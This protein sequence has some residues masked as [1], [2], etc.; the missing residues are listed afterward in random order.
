[1][2]GSDFD[3]ISRRLGNAGSRRK[4]LATL[5]TALGLLGLHDGSVFVLARRHK[6]KKKK[7]RG[8]TT[9]PPPTS[10]ITCPTGYSACG[11]Q[12]FD[13]SDNPSNCG[14][15]AV[16]CSPSKTCCSGVCVDLQD[17]D[18]NCNSCGHAC[19]TRDED[20]PLERAAEICIAGVCVACSV[21]GA[22]HQ[23]NPLTCCRGLHRCFDEM[24]RNDCVPDGTPC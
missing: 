10:T 4:A 14:A 16:V 3:A 9:S 1:M 18:S 15:C 6:K 8:G 22:I 20:T 21:Q 11:E 19:L 13:L 17:N 23:N 7:K 24:G 12:C 5:G 2:D